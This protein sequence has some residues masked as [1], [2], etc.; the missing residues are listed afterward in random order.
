MLAV[1]VTSLGQTRQAWM[2]DSMKK[3]E[4]ELVA[5]YGEGQH[6]R[7]T[8]GLK[9]VADFWR[10]D[11]GDSAAFED[12][13]RTNFAAHQPTLDTLFDRTHVVLESIHASMTQHA[14]PPLRPP[15]P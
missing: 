10:A 6:A 5:K 2:N 12:F 14:R 4:T 3:M 15:G 8:R 9:H 7:V 11:D 1:A 13:V